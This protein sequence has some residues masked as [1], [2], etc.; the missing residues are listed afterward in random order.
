MCGGNTPGSAEDVYIYYVDSTTGYVDQG[1]YTSGTTWNSD[2]HGL[3]VTPATGGPVTMNA[4]LYSG[5][6]THY[7][8]GSSPL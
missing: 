8:V 5:S 6:S 7:M 3:S 2:V 1:T 4:E